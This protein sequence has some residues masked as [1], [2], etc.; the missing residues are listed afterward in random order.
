MPAALNP[1]LAPMA[2]ALLMGAVPMI[3]HCTGG[4]DRTGVAI[5]LL[6]SLLGVLRE[7]ILADYMRS[8]VFGQNLRQSGLADEVFRKI[9]GFVP[10]ESIMKVMNDTHSA[11]LSAALATVEDQWGSI[12]SYFEAGRVN[13]RRQDELRAALLEFPPYSSVGC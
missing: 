10:S 3:V 1:Y 13:P 6:L 9:I 7:D 12:A 8:D 11:F 2:D 4:K 5:A